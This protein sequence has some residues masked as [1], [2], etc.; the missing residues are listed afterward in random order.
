MPVLEGVLG[1]VSPLPSSFLLAVIQ[2]APNSRPPVLLEHLR[3]HVV[4]LFISDGAQ[5]PPLG[6]AGLLSVVVVMG[7]PDDVVLRSRLGLGLGSGRG[8]GRRPGRGPRSIAVLARE[9]FFDEVGSSF[10]SSVGIFDVLVVDALEKGG[11]L[12][13]VVDVS[14]GLVEQCVEIEDDLASE[15][16]ELR[17]QLLQLLVGFRLLLLVLLLINLLLL[18][19][20]LD[21]APLLE[22]F[23]LSGPVL[24]AL[25][26]DVL[27]VLLLDLGDFLFRWELNILHLSHLSVVPVSDIDSA[28]VHL[29]LDSVEKEVSF[30]LVD[31]LALGHLVPGAFHGRGVVLVDQVLRVQILTLGKV[32]LVDL[33]VNI[34]TLAG[35]E[36]ERVVEKILRV[37][38]L[39]WYLRF[40]CSG[41]GGGHGG[42]CGRGLLGL[43]LL[44]FSNCVWSNCV[45][46][47]LEISSQGIA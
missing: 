38:V 17:H 22:H 21:S 10:L 13:S 16:L 12:T 20:L 36:L 11:T 9:C 39:L 7:L 29:L 33:G 24:S 37:L 25:L 32:I 44:G 40:F 30:T 42:N 3:N 14:L 35:A 2:A 19:L 45:R 26:L 31:A 6:P 43:G 4:F 46:S 28:F 5:L 8:P 34:L 41:G 23:S 47:S 15:G 27:L 1:S 18:K